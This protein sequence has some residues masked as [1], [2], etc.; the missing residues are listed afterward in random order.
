MWMEVKDSHGFLVP[1]MDNG[2]AFLSSLGLK[3]KVLLKHGGKTVS[4]QHGY[5]QCQLLCI[6]REG[7][8]ERREREGREGQEE[9]AG[10][11]YLATNGK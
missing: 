4:L 7:R 3:V 10:R 8:T 1:V 11:C 6:G 9:Q 2:C 5:S